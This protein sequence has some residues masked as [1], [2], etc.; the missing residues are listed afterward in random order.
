MVQK[1]LRTTVYNALAL[2]VLLYGSEIWTLR[3][4]IKNYLYQKDDVSKKN[5][6]VHPFWPQRNQE[7]LEEMN[8]KPFDEK[9][10]RYKSNWLRHVTRMDNNRML[11]VM[12]NYRPNGRR[13]FGKPSKNLLDEVETCL[14]RPNSWRMMMMVMMMMLLLLLMMM[15]MH[16]LALG[17]HLMFLR[18]LIKGRDMYYFQ[19]EF[20]FR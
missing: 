18:R 3:K 7:I 19:S 16:F 14:W 8:L 13:R 10:R 5:S 6:Q 4:K 17:M 9:L 15:M 1:S 11:K 2:P 20:V 12:L